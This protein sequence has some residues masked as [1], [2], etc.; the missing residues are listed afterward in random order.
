MN[1]CLLKMIVGSFFAENMAPFTSSTIGLNPREPRENLMNEED[2][3]E[4]LDEFFHSLGE[5]L[6]NVPTYRVCASLP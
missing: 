5:A 1:D 4:L 3:K 6:K 2:L